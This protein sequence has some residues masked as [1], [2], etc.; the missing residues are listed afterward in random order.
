MRIR[1][2]S[3]KNL[4][5]WISG[6]CAPAGCELESPEMVGADGLEPPTSSV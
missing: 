4:R 1:Q 5:A 6:G 2:D 3:E